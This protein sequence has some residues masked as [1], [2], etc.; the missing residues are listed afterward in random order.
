MVAAKIPTMTAAEAVALGGLDTS[1][2]AENGTVSVTPENS[3]QCHS[4]EFPSSRNFQRTVI[5][6]GV[7]FAQ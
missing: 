3:R 1:E 4:P 5:A 7:F 6:Q 2:I